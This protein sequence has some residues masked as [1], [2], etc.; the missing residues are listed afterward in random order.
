MSNDP[1]I[2]VSDHPG[3]PRLVG[4]EHGPGAGQHPGGGN[5]AANEAVQFRALR[6]GQHDTI[7]VGQGG[8][9]NS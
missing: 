7:G 5:T 1:A 8:T 3:H 2:T 9:S 6:F 4:L